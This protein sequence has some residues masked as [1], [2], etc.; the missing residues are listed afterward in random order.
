V[1]ILRILA[2]L[3]AF[4]IAVSVVSWILTRDRRYLGISWRIAQAAFAIA[5]LL[6]V[7]LVG[8]RLIVL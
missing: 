3:A 2:L 4:G 5:L 8:E 1:L 6:M 7:F